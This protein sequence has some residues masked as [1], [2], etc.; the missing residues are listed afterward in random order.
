MEWYKIVFIFSSLILGIQLLMSF[1]STDSDFDVDFDG[2]LTIGDVFSFKGLV[3]FIFGTSLT[4]T[5]FDIN[6]RQLVWSIG[7]FC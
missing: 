5:V 3:H 1:F 4:L 2:E 7:V 6:P